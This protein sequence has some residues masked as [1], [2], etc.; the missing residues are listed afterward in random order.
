MTVIEVIKQCHLE[1]FSKSYKS[2]YG[3]SL[4]LKYPLDTLAK[5]EV[6][7]VYINFPQNTASIVLI[8]FAF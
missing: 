8:D 6:K 4:D 7:D 5:M 1:D 3:T 2:L